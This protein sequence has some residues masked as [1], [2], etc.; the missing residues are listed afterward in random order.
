MR[1]C[2]VI[3]LCLLLWLICYLSSGNDLKNMF[4]YRSYPKEVQDILK[5]DEVLSKQIPEINM[6]K[7]I[8]ENIIL[9]TVI[10]SAII[11]TIL[12]SGICLERTSSFLRIS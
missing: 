12:I 8:A 3:G 1:A 6:V 5:N 11:L 7:I 10:F 2:F 4:G 9:F